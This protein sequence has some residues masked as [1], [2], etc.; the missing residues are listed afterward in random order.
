ML[1]TPELKTFLFDIATYSLGGFFVCLVFIFWYL[2]KDEES[3]SEMEQKFTIWADV[4]FRYRDFTRKRFGK[5]HFIYYLAL[6]FLTTVTLMFGLNFF[7]HI[8]TIQ[9]PFRYLIGIAGAIIL[10]FV[11]GMFYHISKNEYYK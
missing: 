5:V 10:S 9:A 1:A 8:Q 4:L 11:I 6:F 7:L 2:R 3:T